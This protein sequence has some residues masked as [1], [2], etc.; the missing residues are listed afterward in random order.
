MIENR[1]KHQLIKKIWDI[2]TGRQLCR[3]GG[4]HVA[5]E[6]AL[7]LR[8]KC[9]IVILIYFNHNIYHDTKI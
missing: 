3:K 7:W 4:S 5:K 2:Y 6:I 8:T 9:L 1:S